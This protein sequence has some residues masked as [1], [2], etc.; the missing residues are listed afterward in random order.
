M[1]DCAVIKPDF[2]NVMKFSTCLGAFSGKNTMSMSPNFVLIVALGPFVT[3]AFPTGALSAAKRVPIPSNRL[4]PS[5][6]VTATILTKIR[7]CIM[8]LPGVITNLMAQSSYH[9]DRIKPLIV[10]GPVSPPVVL[11]LS[12]FGRIP[13]RRLLPESTV[14][15]QMISG[16]RAPFREQSHSGAMCHAAFDTTPET[17]SCSRPLQA[18]PVARQYA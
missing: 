17:V 6:H 8:C 1:K 10:G 15:P 5:T 14:P 11:P 12:C 9:G 2:A 3:S 16:G 13:H 18:V 7:L 4:P